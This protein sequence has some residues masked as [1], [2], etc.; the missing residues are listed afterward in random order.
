MRVLVMLAAALFWAA[1]AAA[2]PLAAWVQLDG[3]GAEA[4]AVTDAKACP[5]I[6]VD[7]QLRPMHLRSGPVEAFANRICAA[8]IPAKAKAVSVEGQVL[9][10]PKARPLR[11]VI[12]GDTGCRVKDRKIQ[13]CADQTANGWPFAKVAALAAA[14]HPDLVIHVGDYY[15]RE[16]QCPPQRCGGGP[17]GDTWATW[18]A[19][20]FDPAAPLLKAA[21]WVF[22]RGNHEDCDRVGPGWF[23]LIDAGAQAKTCPADADPFLVDI[24]GL[25]LAVL[26]SAMPDDRKQSPEAV[27]AFQTQLAVAAKAKGPVW[28]VT[29]RPVWAL[30][31]D[32]SGARWG[33]I[34]ERVALERQPVP[35]AQ[36]F[37][38]GHVHD[39]TSFDFG[40]GRLPELIVGT[41]GTALED[42]AGVLG[43]DGTID[44]NGL[45]AKAY[46]TRQ[47]GYFVFERQGSAWRGVFRDLDDHVIV[48]CDLAKARLTCTP[49]SQ[50]GKIG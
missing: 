18:R 42:K 41:G 45:T 25:T 12:F 14:R 17:T 19:D 31:H 38:A 2:A 3:R 6:R 35:G 22:A 1:P 29:H 47:Y 43:P 36:L 33:N 8:R 50:P 48:R 49:V 15:Y 4:R 28:I 44:M 39:F 32:Q 7:G 9:P 37:L 21:P 40:P 23:R 46:T 34:N 24:G 30:P 26:D 13:D 16:T 27:A 5:S 11:L 10:V 20:F